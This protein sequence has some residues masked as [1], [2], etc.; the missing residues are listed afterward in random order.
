MSNRLYIEMYNNTRD[1][2][3]SRYPKTEGM[4]FDLFCKQ[5]ECFKEN[6]NV[7]TMEEAIEAW[8]MPEGQE[9][10]LPENAFC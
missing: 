10:N 2:K 6:F 5:L 8:N 9:T 3:N 4:D 1:L 7:I